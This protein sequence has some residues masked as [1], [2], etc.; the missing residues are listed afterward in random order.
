MKTNLYLKIMIGLPL[1]IFI[2]Y[3][4]MAMLGCISCFLGFGNGYFCGP[5]CLLGKGLL[6]LSAILF[7]LYIFPDVKSLFHAKKQIDS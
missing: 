1:V 7:C 6:V 5:Y 4:L 2:D 3:L